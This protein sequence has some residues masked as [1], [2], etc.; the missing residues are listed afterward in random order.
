MGLRIRN[1]NNNNNDNSNI[2][3]ASFFIRRLT[4]IFKRAVTRVVW[5]NCL[6]DIRININEPEPWAINNMMCV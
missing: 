1:N 3:V 6:A 4:D 2:K 5:F